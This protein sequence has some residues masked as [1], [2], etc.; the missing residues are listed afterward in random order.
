MSPDIGRSIYIPGNYKINN[1]QNQP[2][3]KLVF[4][5][6]IINRRIEREPKTYVLLIGAENGSLTV[7]TVGL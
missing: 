1:Y 2:K 4:S 7:R 5:V 6:F 3:V